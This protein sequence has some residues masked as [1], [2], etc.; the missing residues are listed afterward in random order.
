MQ[1][2]L[3]PIFCIGESLDDRKNKTYRDFL[4]SQIISSTPKDIEIKNLIL[5]YE[6]IWSIGTGLTPE[7]SAISEIVD[8]VY[9]ELSKYE[10]IKNFKIIYGG[11][12]KSSNSSEILS[13]KN[14]NGLLV[15]NCKF[16]LRGIF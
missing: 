14:I 2:T 1:K 11:S 13:I 10:N 12:V 8:F 15:G 5:A 3:L 7:I 9:N 16:K 6:P 4:R